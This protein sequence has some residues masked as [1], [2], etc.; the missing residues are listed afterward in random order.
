MNSEPSN[1]AVTGVILLSTI[2]AMGFGLW[3]GSF[4]AAL[5]AWPILIILISRMMR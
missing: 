2:G 4:G 5:L 3:V 1:G